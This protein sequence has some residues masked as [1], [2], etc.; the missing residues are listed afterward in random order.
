MANKLIT[1]VICYTFNVVG[2]F[3]HFIVVIVLFNWKWNNVVR[4]KCGT[5]KKSY[6]ET[7]A[8]SVKELNDLWL[9]RYMYVKSRE[10]NK[11]NNNNKNL[12]CS[13]DWIM[14]SKGWPVN[15]VWAIYVKRVCVVCWHEWQSLA[16]MLHYSFVLKCAMLSLIALN[17]LVRLIL[18]FIHIYKI[19]S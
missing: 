11:K 5:K 1:S 6:T 14:E 3:F 8:S 17:G 12:N 19:F 15:R 2:Y 18:H 16:W 9:K 13:E 4:I 7:T 10:L